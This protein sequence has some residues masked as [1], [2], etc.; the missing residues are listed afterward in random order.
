MM[1]QTVE[2]IFDGAALQP[3]VP[4][5][6]KAGTR[7]RI[8][9]ESVLPDEKKQQK[10]FLQTARSLRLEGEPDWSENID[11]Y[12]NGEHVSDDA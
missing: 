7:V 3:E 6:L 1:L 9:V 4:L 5:N 10:S 8:T 12:V 11:Q 2:A